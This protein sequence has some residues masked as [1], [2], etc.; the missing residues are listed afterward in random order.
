MA[1]KQC[2]I[3]HFTE[4]NDLPL[5]SVHDHFFYQYPTHRHDFYEMEYVLDGEINYTLNGE[6]TTLK[7]GDV[8]FVTPS[9]VHSYEG[10]EEAP[11]STITI[12][13]NVEAVRSF[14]KLFLLQDG[15]V[16]V[17]DELERAF[18]VLNDENTK[19]DAFSEAALKNA[20]ERVLILFL[21][22]AQHLET[23]SPSPDIFSALSYINQNF[24]E[25]ISL[26]TLSEICGYSLSYLCRLFKQETGLTPIQYL[27]KIRM[28]SACR[29]LASTDL[30]VI[31]ICAECGC[32]CVRNFNREFKKRF[33]LTPI[34]YRKANIRP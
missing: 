6:T 34:E 5:I 30:S 26:S 28:E 10:S 25:D 19:K 7:K 1:Y 31:E 15:I 16:C 17:T 14:P 2:K 12:H 4:L 23:K 20:F 9:S 18:H 27:N 13:F 21:R 33:G 8:A 11:I 29:L 32:G 3:H 24:A 22:S